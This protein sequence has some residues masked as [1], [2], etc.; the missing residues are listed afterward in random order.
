MSDLTNY[1]EKVANDVAAGV[2]SPQLGNQM[3][4]QATILATPSG[5]LGANDRYALRYGHLKTPPPPLGP[6]PTD[7]IDT[8]QPQPEETTPIF[9]RTP[10]FRMPAPPPPPPT[11]PT[12]PA[13]PPAPE[14]TRGVK[15]ATP[16]IIVFDEDS[17]D[18]GFLIEAFFEEFGGTELIN[19]SRTD[20]INGDRVS[21]SPIVNL[22]EIY[23]KYN[24]NNIISISQYQ[25]LPTK[26]GIDLL[27]REPEAPYFDDNGDMV[28]EVG[29]VKNDESIEVEFALNGTISRI[30]Q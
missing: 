23:R 30:E 29:I 15:Q 1:K 10:R 3:I 27:S 8:P 9:F 26:Y 12:P 6:L 14:I 11:P 20:L 25:E 4:Q 18:P 17:V 19:I 13:P 24:P 5:D 28:I 2:I 16:D 7:W 21:Y 22:S